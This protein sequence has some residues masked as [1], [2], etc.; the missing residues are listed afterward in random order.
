MFDH[1]LF[2]KA[3]VERKLAEISFKYLE[4]VDNV[5]SFNTLMKELEIRHGMT[6]KGRESQLSKLKSL[7]TV[8]ED[9]VPKHAHFSGILNVEPSPFLV[10]L[11]L[12]SRPVAW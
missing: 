12:A 10:Q 8:K 6:K 1:S 7:L 4:T 3:N 2:G 9:L 11:P 5:L